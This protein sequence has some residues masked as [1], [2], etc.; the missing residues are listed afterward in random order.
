MVADRDTWWLCDSMT[1]QGKGG[2]HQLDGCWMTLYHILQLTWCVGAQLVL[3]ACYLL[4]LRS[5]G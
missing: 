3:S 2:K 1:C 4:T 5:W